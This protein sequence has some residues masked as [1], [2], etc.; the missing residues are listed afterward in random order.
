MNYEKEM[1]GKEENILV[2]KQQRTERNRRDNLNKFNSL[3]N[4]STSV[5]N[6]M[7]E[8]PSVTINLFDE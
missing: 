6:L 4:N 5:S 8:I 1:K 2:K 3:S 7:T